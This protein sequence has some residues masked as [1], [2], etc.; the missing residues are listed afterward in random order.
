MFSKP[1]G[2]FVGFPYE[3]HVQAS[4]ELYVDYLL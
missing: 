4:T 1:V 3:L 2:F